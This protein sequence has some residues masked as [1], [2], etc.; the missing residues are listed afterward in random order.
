VRVKTISVRIPGRKLQAIKIFT[1]ESAK[2]KIPKAN[3][4]AEHAENAEINY[5]KGILFLPQRTQRAQS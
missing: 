3:L 2:E 4:T 5:S 1:V